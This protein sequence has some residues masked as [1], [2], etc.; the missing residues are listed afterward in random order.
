VPEPT[1]LPL[2]RLYENVHAP[3]IILDSIA[4]LR[5]HYMN[6]QF[7]VTDIGTQNTINTVNG[8]KLEGS[9]PCAQ[10]NETGTH[11][12]QMN[13]M[14]IITHNLRS[15]FILSSLSKPLSPKQ[16]FAFWFPDYNFS[17]KALKCKGAKR[18]WKKYT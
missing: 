13:S 3:Y 2:L 10:Q 16:S 15:M 6:L 8:I 12:E 17:S 4:K 18:I 9:L 11:S 7:S 1:T 5:L 14:H